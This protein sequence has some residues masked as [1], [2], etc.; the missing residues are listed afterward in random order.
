M[1]EIFIILAPLL[2]LGLGKNR[3]N[4]GIYH[5]TLLLNQI[6][7]IPTTTKNQPEINPM[8]RPAASDALKVTI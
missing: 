1:V 7:K 8:K 6:D 2:G 4:M 3:V 5:Y